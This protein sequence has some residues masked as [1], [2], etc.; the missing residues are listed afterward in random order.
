VTR[1][2]ISTGNFNDRACLINFMVLS[3]LPIPRLASWICL[4]P[5]RETRSWQFD[6]SLICSNLSIV[7][8]VIILTKIFLER[9]WLTRW[10]KSLSV[11][12]SPPQNKTDFR[13]IFF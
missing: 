9:I 10:G 12:T 6:G 13:L 4:G 8:L 2:M 3:K 1:N 11:K 7:P 5:S